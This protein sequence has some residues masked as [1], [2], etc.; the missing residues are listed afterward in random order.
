MCTVGDEKVL[1]RQCEGNFLT[2]PGSVRVYLPEIA[3][4]FEKSLPILAKIYLN[5][6][7]TDDS[8]SHLAL[9]VV[10]MTHI[11]TESEII[12]TSWSSESDGNE[13]CQ[14]LAIPFD[15]KIEVST[16]EPPSGN[17]EDLYQKTRELFERFHLSEIKDMKHSRL[18]TSDSTKHLQ[19]KLKGPVR[20]GYE[21]Q[22]VIIERPTRAYSQQFRS[23]HA[24]NAYLCALYSCR[25]QTYSS[26]EL[27]MNNNDAN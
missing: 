4:F 19:R 27:F 2:D 13:V 12:A 16:I 22:G 7:V 24:G 20:K 23:T 11:S 14:P 21:R 1:Y 3:K 18:A 8:I 10:K 6:D 25:R 17:N 15:L 5:S 9:K 26:T